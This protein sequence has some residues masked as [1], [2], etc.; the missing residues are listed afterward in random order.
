MLLSLVH[1]TMQ[2]LRKLDARIEIISILA[3]DVGVLG[4]AP[5][6][7]FCLRHIVNQALD[8]AQ[9]ISYL[10]KVTYIVVVYSVHEK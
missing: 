9:Q 6:Q 2:R 8:V 7:R 1:N 4:D 3:L 10:N 5:P